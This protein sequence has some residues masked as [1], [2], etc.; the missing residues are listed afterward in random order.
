MYI[1]YSFKSL[2]ISIL[3]NLLL[4]ISTYSLSISKAKNFLL[5]LI[6]AIHVEPVP[7]KTSNTTSPLFDEFV[8]K[9]SNNSTGFSVGCVF[10]SLHY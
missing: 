10:Y 6:A 5:F 7:A 2:C 1:I 3:S 9:H 4:A 8:I